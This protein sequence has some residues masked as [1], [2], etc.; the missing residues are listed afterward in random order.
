MTSTLGS[1]SAAALPDGVAALAH[2]G[3]IRARGADAADFLRRQLTSDVATLDAGQAKLAGYCSAKGRLL[4]SFVAWRP[5]EDEVL[6]A[7]S[8]SLL[9]ATLKRLRMFVLRAKCELGDATAEV[10]LHGVACADPATAAAAL[11]DEAARAAVWQRVR[12][13]DGASLIRLP[14]AA[15][16]RRWLLAAPPG[17]ALPALPPLAADAWRWLEVASGVAVVEAATADRHVP[18]MLNFEL[19]G[20]VDFGK[21]CYPGQEVVARSQYRGTLKRRSLL[22]ALDD[23]AA[24]AGQEVFHSDDPGQPAGEVV[25]A[26]AAPAGGGAGA[27]ALVELKFAALDAGTLHL[28]APGGPPLRPVAMPYEVPLHTVDPA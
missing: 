9:D 16:R 23:G 21:G 7:C 2:W 20:G 13:G 5:A 22:F 19:L 26:A 1:P 12:G 27:L 10:A 3:V 8:A 17:A 14:D 11:G 6:L 15:G 28:G 4:A 25:N 24:S 18:Q